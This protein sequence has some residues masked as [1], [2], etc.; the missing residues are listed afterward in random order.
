MKV[1]EVTTHYSWEFKSTNF[2]I[3]RNESISWNVLAENDIDAREMGIDCLN[4][5][6]RREWN[7]FKDDAKSAFANPIVHYCEIKKICLLDQ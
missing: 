3:N 7:G 1:F 6:S 4:R 5:F 2:K